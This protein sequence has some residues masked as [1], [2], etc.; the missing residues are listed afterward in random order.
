MSLSLALPAS[1]VVVVGLLL[2]VVIL[3]RGNW[4]IKMALVSFCL[5]FAVVLYY[6]IGEASGWPTD[7]R[8]PERFLL[9]GACVKEPDKKTGD[10]GSICLWMVPLDEDHDYAA[11]QRSWLR[12]F[13]AGGRPGEPRAV[14]TAY[15]RKLHE[16]VEEARERSKGGRPV[17]FGAK[18]S[19]S[20]K[21]GGSP[22]ENSLTRDTE[23]TI[24]DLP[25]ALLPEKIND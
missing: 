15:D 16:A 25:P 24:Y 12:P 3:G 8:P 10:R 20:E 11:T 5:Y 4:L 19:D 2:W 23:W 9:Y 1:F 18:K 13:G 17:V 22:G 21:N 7:G 6:G 14:R